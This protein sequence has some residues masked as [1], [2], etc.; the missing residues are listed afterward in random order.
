MRFVVKSSLQL[1]CFFFPFFA[2]LTLAAAEENLIAFTLYEPATDGIKGKVWTLGAKKPDDM[3]ANY[4]IVDG[5]DG[6]KALEI[7]YAGTDANAHSAKTFVNCPKDLLPPEWS[8]V[9]LRLTAECDQDLP[10]R[11]GIRLPDKRDSNFQTMVAKGLN[12]VIIRPKRFG[13]EGRLTIPAIGFWG[14]NGI[15]WRIYKI[16][17][18]AEEI[19]PSTPSAPT[20]EK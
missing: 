20:P 3:K 4:A 15:A 6:K 8:L 5:K 1:L 17:I 19:K 11:G 13:Y 18:L 7:T 12:E 16:E 14:A 10:I 9:A 2:T